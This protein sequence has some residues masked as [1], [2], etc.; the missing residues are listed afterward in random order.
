MSSGDLRNVLPLHL[1]D[2]S[3]NETTGYDSSFNHTT[4]EIINP[5]V[6]E[7][8][9]DAHSDT[10]EQQ[11]HDVISGGG[12]DIGKTCTDHGGLLVVNTL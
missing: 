1:L 10:S 9:F 11:Q 7:N 8:D 2:T 4:E 6:M 12:S 5:E 3:L